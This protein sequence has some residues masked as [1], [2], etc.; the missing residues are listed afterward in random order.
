MERTSV[1]RNS[2]RAGR[3]EK[4]MPQVPIPSAP[5]PDDRNV[6]ATVLFKFV[7]KRTATEV[8]LQGLDCRASRIRMS[9][10]SSSG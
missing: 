8:E 9:E 7:P 3:S 5:K 10:A 4:K 2:S 6:H 1:K